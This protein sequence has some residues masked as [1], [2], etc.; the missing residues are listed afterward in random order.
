MTTYRPWDRAWQDALYSPAGFYRRPEGP[1]GHF[2]TAAHASS[3]GLLGSA[4][5]RLAGL[6]GCTAVV[7]VGAGRGELLIAVH[8][9][10]EGLRCTGVD[11]VPRPP[12]L[13]EAVGWAAEPPATGVPTLL[14]GWELLDVVPCPV[15]EVAGDGSVRVVEVA[16][17]GTERLAGE[18]AAEDLA[19]CE[20]WWPLEGAPPGTRAE[21]GRTRDLAWAALAGS[22]QGTGGLALAVD[23]GHDHGARPPAGTLTGYCEGRQVAP[24]PDGSCDVTAHVALDSVAAV[25]PG[26][27]RLTQREALA[28]LGVTGARPPL[29]LAGSD[30]LAYLAALARAGEAAELLD[31]AGFGGFGWVL[32]PVGAQVTGALAKWTSGASG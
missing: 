8:A 25:R 22:L 4:L 3:S 24:V 5:A 21:V 11:V 19:W 9:A 20:R 27:V 26:A 32:H 6:A 18:P 28:R 7:D 29:T 14:V 16:P 30:P 10:E 31:P 13:P 12:G 2:R 1:A 23:Y 17:D 15:L